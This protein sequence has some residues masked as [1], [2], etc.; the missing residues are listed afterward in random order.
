MKLNNIE[1]LFCMHSI[2]VQFYQSVTIIVIYNFYILYGCEIWG[3][4][5]IS[6]KEKVYIDFLK[7]FYT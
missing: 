2:Q 5:D 3:F 7:Y 6:I 1:D 4:G